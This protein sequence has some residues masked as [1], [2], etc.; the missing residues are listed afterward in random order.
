[1]FISTKG[2]EALDK[3]ERAGVLSASEIKS[4]SKIAFGKD[5]TSH[6]NI[7]KLTMTKILRRILSE[8]GWVS[9]LGQQW[10]QWARSASWYGTF[11][12]FSKNYRVISL[13]VTH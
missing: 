5:S 7:T 8:V 13:F 12:T 2:D 9:T 4:L 6:V 3:M 11:T 1:M 10:S